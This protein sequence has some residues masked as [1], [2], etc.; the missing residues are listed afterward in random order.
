MGDYDF[1]PR[2][3]PSI[4]LQLKEKGAMV[5]VRL[6]SSPYRE[7]KVWKEGV[8]A[9]LDAKEVAALTEQQ[10]LA[11]YRNP[12][13]NITEAF[14]W[15]VIDRDS[16]QAKIFTSTA[17]VYKNIKKYAEM[18]AW[19]DPTTY[20]FQIERTEQPGP[21][22]YAV[23]AVPNKEPLNDKESELAKNMIDQLGD[24]LPAARKVTEVQVDFLPSLDEASE[25]PATGKPSQKDD[26]VIEDIGEPINLDDIPF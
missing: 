8:R 7:P 21:S 6:V 15:V 17:G 14:H 23:V 22:Y 25:E 26:I 13:Y 20:D 16:G 11:L 9:P 19:G 1:E 24:K 12:D 3:A 4:Y 10:W 5:M 18:A 2:S